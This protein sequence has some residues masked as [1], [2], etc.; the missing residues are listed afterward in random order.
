[1]TTHKVQN[2]KL[3]V[4]VYVNPDT[5]QQEIRRIV[6]DKGSLTINYFFLK[7]A[8]TQIFP[9]LQ[10]R[11]FKLCWK[12]K[13]NIIC[14]FTRLKSKILH[15]SNVMHIQGR[16]LLTNPFVLSKYPKLNIILDIAIL[17]VSVIVREVIC[18]SQ[19]KI[20]L[21]ELN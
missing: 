5:D 12:G 20:K 21:T 2:A 18:K 1:M 15:R 10:G 4:K 9:H 6:C 16:T 8:I 3:T 11:N 7:N 19:L 13:F 14:V 17:H